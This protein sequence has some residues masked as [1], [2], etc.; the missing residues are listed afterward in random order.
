MSEPLQVIYFICIGITFLFSFVVLVGAPFLPTLKKQVDSAFELLD[1]KPGQTMLELGSGDGRML[2]AAARRGIKSVGYEIN[3]LLYVYSRLITRKY[4][5]Y[6]RV[7]WGNY[8]HKQWPQS[9]GIF[10]FLLQS[11]MEKLDKKIID[12]CNKPVRLVSLAFKIKERKHS[13]KKNGLFLYI[14]K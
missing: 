13:G 10:V 1:L 12:E 9:D 2:V 3:P 6:V 7:I 8:W 14:Y 4:R 5:K 11:Y